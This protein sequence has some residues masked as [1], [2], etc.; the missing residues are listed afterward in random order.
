MLLVSV[1][2]VGYY[3]YRELHYI[4]IYTKYIIMTFKETGVSSIMKGIVDEGESVSVLYIDGK[5]STKYSKSHEAEED[6]K[7]LRVKFP[8]KKIEIKQEV[9]E[10]KQRLDPKCWKGKHKE[11]TKIKG[12]VRV[13]NCVPNESVEEASSPAQQAAI[14]I[15]MKK[16]GKKPKNEDYTGQF[17]AERTAAINPYGGLKDRQYRGAINEGDDNYEIGSQLLDIAYEMKEL[18]ESA[19]R[20]VRGTPEEGR[21]KS[22]WYPHIL[23]AITDDHGYM[24]KNMAT[25]MGSAEA[26]MSGDEDEIGEARDPAMVKAANKNLVDLA[27]GEVRRRE[28]ARRKA[29]KAQRQ[30]S[31]Y[32]ASLDRPKK[33]SKQDLQ[34]LWSKIE[35]VISNSFPDGDPYD[36]LWPYMQKNGFTQ[37]DVE[38]ASKMN[39]YK[40][41]WDY[42]DTLANDIETDMRYDWEHSGRQGPEP[43]IHRFGMNETPD[44]SGPI[45]TQPG[46]WRRTDMD[47]DTSFG[48]GMGQGGNAGQSYR[49]FRPKSAGTFK[50]SA[51]LK[52]ITSES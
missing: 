16:Q 50:E 46:G 38:R 28:I 3:Q 31:K 39:G 2:V 24:G 6:A 10:V 29:E 35:G 23:M 17:T 18:A 1:R 13:N 22:Y 47:E 5:P 8:N 26:L 19:M 45:G 4:S 52:G 15:N 44:T 41:L 36:Q 20:L 27:S 21:A 43:K 9:R 7:R 25:L 14:A 51:I 11:G 33:K 42:W 48:T 30:A 40:D 49:K 37:D 32:L 34:M 12:G